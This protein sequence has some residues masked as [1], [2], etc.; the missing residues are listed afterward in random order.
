MILFFG[1]VRWSLNGAPMIDGELAFPAEEPAEAWQELRV[2]AP[3]GMVTLRREADGIR[4]VTWGNADA[5][6]RFEHLWDVLTEGYE[7]DTLCG[8]VWSAIPLERRSVVV[9]R[10]CAEHSAVRGHEAGA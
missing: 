5:A 2:S 1:T 3:I 6:I 7:T 10:I 4:L 8:Y 9:T